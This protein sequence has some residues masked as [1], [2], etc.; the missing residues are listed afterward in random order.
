MLL[1]HQE[2]CAGRATGCIAAARYRAGSGWL[3]SPG[4]CCLGH[5]CSPCSGSLPSVLSIWPLAIVCNVEVKLKM[6]AARELNAEPGVWSTRLIKQADTRRTARGCSRL[7][8]PVRR[9]SCA[10]SNPIKPQL[11][12]QITPREICPL[13]FLIKRDRAEQL[14]A[15]WRNRCELVQAGIIQ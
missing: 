10:R 4:T 12:L 5:P 8:S 14:C 15:H 3:A 7:L 6:R 1:L 13:G 11:C 9:V 2:P